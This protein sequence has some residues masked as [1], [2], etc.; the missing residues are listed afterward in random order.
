M[1]YTPKKL[2]YLIGGLV[3]VAI[4]LVS[5]VL[6]TGDVTENE[7][8][9]KSTI[10][11]ECPSQITYQGV[12]YRAV[13][14]GGKCWMADNLKAF[15]Y[16]DGTPIDNLLLSGDWAEAEEG[17]YACYYNDERFCNSHGALYNW[18]AVNSQTGLCPEGWRVPRHEH[19]VE[20]EIAVCQDLGYEDCQE[21]FPMEFVSGWRGTDE[22]W[23]LLSPELIGHNKYGFHALFGGFRNAAGPF[24]LLEEEGKESGF[25]WTA[26]DEEEGAYGR[27]L[28]TTE[29]RIRW[30]ASSKSSGFSV[31]CI[32]D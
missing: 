12:V 28:A 8:D 2:Y 19:W 27:V 3:L 25:W 17:A 15:L 5:V 21:Q 31:R 26:S 4:F 6:F 32:M 29:K 7:K 10:I 1:D 13:E 20:L 9:K 23:H 24:M 30:V 11:S 14:I 18:Y 16:R 22:G